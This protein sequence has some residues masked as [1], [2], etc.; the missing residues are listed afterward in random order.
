MTDKRMIKV[1]ALTTGRNTPS[2]RFR[3]RQHIDLLRQFGVDVR[4]HYPYINKYM[5]IPFSLRGSRWEYTPLVD[6][7]WRTLKLSTRIPG[8]LASLTSQITWLQRELLPDYFTLERYVRQP[9]VFDFDDAIWLLSQRADKSIAA[10]VRHSTLVIAGN[11]YLADWA[12]Q[13]NSNTHIV[14]TAIDTARF[15]PN[16]AS[17]DGE[18]KLF[19]VGWTGTAAN[20]PYLYNIEAELRA[21]FDSHSRAQLLVV[22][23]EPPVFE[24]LRPSQVQFIRWSPEIEASS[25][26]EMNVGLMPLPNDPW[27]RGKCSFKMLQYMSSGIP[28]IA[29]SV[30]LNADIL[31]MD[32]IGKAAQRP[33]EWLDALSTYY[34]DR[35]LVRVHGRK[36][37]HIAEKYFSRQVIAKELASIFCSLV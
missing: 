18:D 22:C 4:E 24:T 1:A 15:F 11:A 36:G 19:T 12:K 30:G 28:C 5:R 34:N 37:R 8:Y 2:T 26:R 21:F 17:E 10:I 31:K 16:P 23:E 3:V 14:P 35:H 29:S 33:D 7:L 13:H 6:G 27:T 9:I 25:I 32:Q 20:L